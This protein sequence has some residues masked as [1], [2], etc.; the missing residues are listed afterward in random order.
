[1]KPK[2]KTVGFQL[3]EEYLERL[4]K[5]AAKLQLSAGQYA[6]RLVMNALDDTERKVI[7]EEISELNENVEDLRLCLG[8]AVEALLVTAGNLKKEQARE[9]TDQNIRAAR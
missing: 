8:D 5:E 7:K 6:R 4:E 3:D 1:M 2:P 9:W